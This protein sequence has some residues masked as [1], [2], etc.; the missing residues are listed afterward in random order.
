MQRDPLYLEDIVSVDLAI[1]WTAATIDA[2]KLRDD[3]LRLLA[4]FDAG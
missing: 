2:P 3:V 1:V 4:T